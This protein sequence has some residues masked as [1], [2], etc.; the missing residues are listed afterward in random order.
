MVNKDHLIAQ[1]PRLYHMAEPG[2]WEKIRRHDMGLLSTSELLNQFG[3]NGPCRSS[4]ESKC[5]RQNVCIHHPKYGI[6]VIRDQKPMTPS[7]LKNVLPATISPEE[8]YTL[9]NGK[10]FFW[11]TKK[12]LQ[13]FLEAGSYKNSRHDV[14][15]V[16]TRSLVEQ[17]EATITLSRI[18]SG[19]VRSCKHK[20]GPDTFQT[21]TGHRCRHRKYR[22]ITEC[23]AELTVGNAVLDI[24]HHTLS[25]D[26]WVGATRLENIWSR[27][28]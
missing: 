4:I 10:V 2:T 23:F 16:C 25:V 18:N 11:S 7:K 26:T 21:I 28:C 27:P 24:V 17:C 1:H 3:V 15:T 5:R 6:A 12:R 14:L 8:W 9:L 13:S 19:T 20:R 22:G